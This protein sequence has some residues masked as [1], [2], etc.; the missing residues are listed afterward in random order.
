[1]HLAGLAGLVIMEGDLRGW[2]TQ[3]MYVQGKSLSATGPRWDSAQSLYL[4]GTSLL[5][6]NEPHWRCC[7]CARIIF[8]SGSSETGCG[9]AHW[10]LARCEQSSATVAA[11]AVSNMVP[12]GVAHLMPTQLHFGPMDGS[13]RETTAATASYTALLG[14]RL[15]Q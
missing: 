6:L 15:S 5:G 10:A 4:G 2:V 3:Y 14:L 11:L 9:L 12:P 1:M 8:T 7:F 13:L